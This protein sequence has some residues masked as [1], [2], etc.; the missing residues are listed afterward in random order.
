MFMQRDERAPAGRPP[1]RELDEAVLDATLNLLGEV[2]QEALTMAEVARRAG[3]TTPAIYRRHRNKDE[4]VMAALER[5]LADIAAELP[6]RGSLREDLIAMVGAAVDAMTPLRTRVLAGLVLGGGR[7]TAAVVRLS[8]V[9][10]EN[11]TK[12]LEL[13]VRR[14][15]SRGELRTAR[16]SD[17]LARVPGALVMSANLML[18]GPF[19]DD[20][21]MHLTDQILLPALRA[22]DSEGDDK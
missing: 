22:A 1:N 11:G 3:T 2:G 4:L 19:D 9:L 18:L 21:I 5:E 20:Q 10:G 12:G 14:A 16:H 6:D 7:D 8:E 15:V 13:V 17:L